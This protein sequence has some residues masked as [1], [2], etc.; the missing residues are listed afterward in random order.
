M[1]WTHFGAF[2]VII[3]F[4]IPG[5]KPKGLEGLVPAK[6]QVL[7]EEK[8]LGGAILTFSPKEGTGRTANAT[9]NVKGFFTLGTLNSGDGIAPGEYHVSISKYVVQNPMTNEEIND[10]IMKHDVSPEIIS[11]SVIPDKYADFQKSGLTATIPE[12]G[13]KNLE[14]KLAP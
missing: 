6:G 13:I 3:S 2:F 9:T 8:P 11:K 12:K 4:L 1:R 7:Y 14:F 10:Y 5:C